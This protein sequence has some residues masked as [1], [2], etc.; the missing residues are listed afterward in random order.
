VAAIVLTYIPG[1]P[2]PFGP[3]DVADV[4]PSTPAGSHPRNSAVSRPRT[5]RHTG[6]VDRRRADTPERKVIR[7]F[8]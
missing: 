6:R 5:G 7:P 4:G 3:S 1:P 2:L 8:P